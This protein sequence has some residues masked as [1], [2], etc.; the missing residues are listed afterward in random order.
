M[1]TTLSIKDLSA[2]HELD[3]KTMSAVRGGQI[4]AGVLVR[5]AEQMAEQ[6]D[7][8]CLELRHV[9]SAEVRRQ[10]RVVEQRPVEPVHGLADRWCA[11][12]LVEV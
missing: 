7:L 2:T 6:L 1:Q 11:P 5:T 12:E 9:G 8:M 10:L 3:G 4:T